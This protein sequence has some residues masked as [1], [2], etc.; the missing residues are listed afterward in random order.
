MLRK[1]GALLLRRSFC[2][3]GF[4]GPSQSKVK[5]FDRHLKRKQVS[6]LTPLPIFYFFNSFLFLVPNSFI[7]SWVF[8]CLYDA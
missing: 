5:I 1:G 3:D 6:L 2:S 7:I 8:S 4:S